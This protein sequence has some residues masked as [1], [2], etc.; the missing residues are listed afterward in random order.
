M[1][2]Q[3]QIDVWKRLRKEYAG[4]GDEFFNSLTNLESIIGKLEDP[5]LVAFRGSITD[6]QLDQINRMRNIDAIR[7][8]EELPDP[9]TRDQIFKNLNDATKYLWDT[10]KEFRMAIRRAENRHPVAG[11]GILTD[12]EGRRR[13]SIDRAIRGIIPRGGRPLPGGGEFGTAPI[14]VNSGVR[15][16]LSTPGGI[17]GPLVS[18]A[19]ARAAAFGAVGRYHAAQAGIQ[20]GGE[21]DPRTPTT[22]R[23]TGPGPNIDPIT[24]SRFQKLNEEWQQLLE[25]IKDFDNTRGILDALNVTPFRG[26]RARQIA[27]LIVQVTKLR[28]NFM[29]LRDARIKAIEESGADSKLKTQ[30]IGLINA[31]IE[32]LTRKIRDLSQRDNF[33]NCKRTCCT[34]F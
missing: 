2:Q 13:P 19:A 7:R 29:D 25:N 21:F 17:T 18:G 1:Q 28:K 4:F 3:Q 22:I 5:R 8:G 12:E 11:F 20:A 6:D 16:I 10:S 33:I 14:D 32:Q 30:L 31:P 15:G 24:L 23:G 9:L 26:G 27:E 34:N